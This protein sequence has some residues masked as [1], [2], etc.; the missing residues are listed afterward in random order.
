V[1]LLFEFLPIMGSRKAVNAQNDSREAFSRSLVRDELS[2]HGLPGR[3]YCL[4]PP[5]PEPAGG[6]RSGLIRRLPPSTLTLV[7]G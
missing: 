7:V 4:A 5:R 2:Q 1:V 3:A 6:L